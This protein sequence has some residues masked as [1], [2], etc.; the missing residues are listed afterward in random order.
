M[1]ESS[2]LKCRCGANEAELFFGKMLLDEA[3]VKHLFCPEC[4][5][6]IEESRPDV[7]WDNGWILQLDMDIIRQYSATFSVSGDDLTA[8]WVFDSGYV[9]WVGITPDDTKRRNQE[10]EKIQQLAQTD[11]LAYMQA[12]KNWGQEREK[13]FSKEGWRKMQ[14]LR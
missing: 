10:R 8:E 9:T 13:R 6:N 7:I 12:M 3:S 11:I 5:E 2:I 1:C 14:I 4:S